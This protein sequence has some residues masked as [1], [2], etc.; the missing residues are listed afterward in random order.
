MAKHEM[1]EQLQKLMTDY[2]EEAETGFLE[3]MITEI[4]DIRL[5][6][7]KKGKN[8]GV[9][10]ENNTKLDQNIIRPVFKVKLAP[11]HKKALRVPYVWVDASQLAYD[12]D[13]EH[14][15]EDYLRDHSVIGARDRKY[16]KAIQETLT[17]FAGAGGV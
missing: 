5:E 1:P 13:N 7:V 16:L 2:D 9:Y 6:F 3:L 8:V 4:L 15:L 14:L 12:V 17:C 10:H 11:N